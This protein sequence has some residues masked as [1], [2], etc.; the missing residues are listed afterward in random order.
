[1]PNHYVGDLVAD[2]IEDFGTSRYHCFPQ[3]E[4]GQGRARLLT[5]ATCWHPRGGT[6]GPTE[7]PGGCVSG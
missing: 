3:T 4:E 2:P 6:I 7:Q 5:T 1:M